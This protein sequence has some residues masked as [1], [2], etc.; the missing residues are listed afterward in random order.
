MSC[1]MNWPRKVKPAGIRGLSL[2]ESSSALSGASIPEPARPRA[3]SN[4]SSISRGGKS[5]NIRPYF[6]SATCASA[7][8]NR[9]EITQL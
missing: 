3:R 5:E 8:L 9:G 4:P 2:R 7:P 6:P 1:A